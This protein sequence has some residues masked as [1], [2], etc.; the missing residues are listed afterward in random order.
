VWWRWHDLDDSSVLDRSP[1]G[2]NDITIS[3]R[4][5]YKIRKMQRYTGKIKEK[6]KKNNQKKKK[7]SKQISGS[8]SQLQRMTKHSRTNQN[9]FIPTA[10]RA[11]ESSAKEQTRHD[12][13]T[14]QYS[15]DDA[16]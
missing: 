2:K 10:T 11:Q 7:V 12:R 3:D 1:A 16:Q 6:L 5:K 9:N 13:G 8:S 14:V 4:F 15:T